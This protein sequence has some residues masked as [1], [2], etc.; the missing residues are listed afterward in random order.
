MLDAD[1]VLRELKQKIRRYNAP[2]GDYC[3]YYQVGL[4]RFVVRQRTAILYDGPSLHKAVS[5]INERHIS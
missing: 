3:L 2:L 4:K 5:I 1:K